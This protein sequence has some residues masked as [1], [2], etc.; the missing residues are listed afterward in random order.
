R[1]AG[2]SNRRNWAAAL[3]SRSGPVALPGWSLGKGATLLEEA[4]NDMESPSS[5]LCR[6]DRIETSSAP[7]CPRCGVAGMLRSPAFPWRRGFRVLGGG[8][9]D[10]ARV[11]PRD[12]VALTNATTSL[13]DLSDP[14]ALAAR[15]QAHSGSIGQGNATE[16]LRERSD[17]VE[18]GIV[19][20]GGHRLTPVF[21]Q[22]PPYLEK[23]RRHTRAI[24]GRLCSCSP[25]VIN[26]FNDL[27]R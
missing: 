27:A 25:V 12:V 24:D 6:A 11:E 15:N 13:C 17:F 3:R 2:S 22:W 7:C 20:K 8:V 14:R 5:C 23:I 26:D 4:I 16:P 1:A 18:V 19:G 21:C 10:V 9:E